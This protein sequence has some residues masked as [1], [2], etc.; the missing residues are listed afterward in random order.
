MEHE[1]CPIHLKKLLQEDPLNIRNN[2]Y[3]VRNLSQLIQQTLFPNVHY[4]D[5]ITHI[6]AHHLMETIAM[7]ENND[8]SFM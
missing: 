6:K 3:K 8:D 2:Q 5:S 4:N 1:R 7:P